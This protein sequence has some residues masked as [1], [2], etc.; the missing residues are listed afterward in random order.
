MARLDIGTWLHVWGHLKPAYGIS[1]NAR[2]TA[3]LWANEVDMFGGVELPLLAEL[4]ESTETEVLAGLAEAAE[5][6]WLVPDA[7]GPNGYAVAIPEGYVFV[8]QTDRCPRC[9]RDAA[10]QDGARG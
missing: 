10:M 9:R 5:R 6:G 7:D 8:P 3:T 2:M 1:P 4:C